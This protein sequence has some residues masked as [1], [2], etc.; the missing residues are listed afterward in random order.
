MI[1]N[2]ASAGGKLD[3]DDQGYK[4]MYRSVSGK[5]S[6]SGMHPL[7]KILIIIVGG[8]LI[9]SFILVPVMALILYTPLYLG[10]STYFLFYL[11][12]A[13]Q[14]S[15]VFYGLDL[16]EDDFKPMDLISIKSFYQYFP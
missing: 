2:A 13:L 16:R 6:N 10:P 4:R 3:Y 8:Y 11:E 15:L 12:S 5:K 1:L 7:L 14:L 9:F